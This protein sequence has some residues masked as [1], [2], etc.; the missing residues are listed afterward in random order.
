M[1]NALIIGAGVAGTSAASVLTKAGWQVRL[2]DKARAPGGR[3]A[4]RRIAADPGSAWF[5]YGA[6]YFTADDAAFRPV[7]DA[8]LAAGH[9]NCWQPAIQV[10][11]PVGDGW[12]RASSPDRRR[13]LV[14]PTGLNHWI[15]H[16]LA[17][18]GAD[19]RCVA[20]VVDVSAQADG[21]RVAIEH[22]PAPLHANALII[23]TPAPQAATLLAGLGGHIGQIDALAHADQALRACQ[24]LVVEAP[25]LPDCHGLFVKGGVLAWIADN[26]HKAGDTAAARRLWT[27][28]ATPEFSDA[29]VEDT[30]ETVQQILMDEFSAITGIVLAQITPVRGHR[31]RYARPGDGAPDARTLCHVEPEIRLA[32]AGDW[33]AGGRVEGAW[34]SGRAAAQALLGQ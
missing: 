22:D 10:A 30:P 9:L 11:E 2:L 26:T 21:W 19:I 17:Q 4:T 7:V 31:W 24:S 20:R 12:R 29:H 15:R 5:D 28:H 8:D 33:L 25:A 27:L 34:L 1:P 16:R 23:T 18:T 13:R 6:Q 14:A 3:C 32:L